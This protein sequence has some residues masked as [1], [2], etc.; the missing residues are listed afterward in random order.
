MTPFEI[1]NKIE[2]IR[3]YIAS[4]FCCPVESKRL[5]AE[6]EKLEK[7]LEDL[8]GQQKQAENKRKED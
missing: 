1:K 5:Y 8:N 6:R 4:P 7:M 3:S 2:E